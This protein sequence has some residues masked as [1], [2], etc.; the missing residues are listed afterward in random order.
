MAFACFDDKLQLRR[1]RMS[2]GQQKNQLD[3]IFS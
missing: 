3:R 2:P 1:H